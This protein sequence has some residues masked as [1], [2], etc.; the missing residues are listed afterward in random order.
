[1]SSTNDK[2]IVHCFDHTHF[3]NKF[4]YTS[5]HHDPCRTLPTCNL[6]KSNKTSKPDATRSSFSWRK[7]VDSASN[8]VSRATPAPEYLSQRRWKNPTLRSFLSS[9]QSQ[10]KHFSCTSIFTCSPSPPS[11]CSEDWSLPCWKSS[12]VLAVLRTT[13][14]YQACICRS[15]SLK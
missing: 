2:Q 8:S 3:T 10:K 11:S 12:S 13:N 14:S 1:M 5:T 6:T 7:S 15:S 4:K 9:H